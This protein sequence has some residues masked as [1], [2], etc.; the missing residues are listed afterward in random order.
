[1]KTFWQWLFG[2]LF[3]LTIAVALGK[4]QE[5]VWDLSEPAAIVN[6][7]IITKGE[8]IDRLMA[9]F[10]EETLKQLI[11]LKLLEQEAQKEG[12][13]L[14]EEEIKQRFEELKAKREELSKQ[15]GRGRLSDLTLRDEAKRL[16]LLEKLVGKRAD[17][18]EKELRDFYRRHF[19]RYNRPERVQIREIIVTTFEEAKEIYQRLAKTAPAKLA[20]EFERLSKERSVIPGAMGEF[21][22]MELPEDMRR[23]LQKAQPN[24]ILPPMPVRI[25]G[26]TTYRIVWVLDKKPGEQNPFEKVRDRVRQ[27]Y[28]VERMVIL[29]P[30]LIERLWK[31]AKIKYTVPFENGTVK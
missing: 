11:T 28:L 22:Y 25:A 15:L 14:T 31:Q 8:L 30:E 5:R 9:D 17:F 29:A 2:F 18:T 20:S 24:E 1:M 23:P 7:S 10:G 21:T 4:Q 16:I 6:E 13:T 27:D 19:I 3:G 26:Q 12:I